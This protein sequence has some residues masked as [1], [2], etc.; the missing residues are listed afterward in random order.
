M[1]GPGGG[2]HTVPKKYVNRQRFFVDAAGRYPR[3][4]PV[5]EY[6]NGRVWSSFFADYRKY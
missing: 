6:W 1:I 3:A 2:I 5:I 4:S